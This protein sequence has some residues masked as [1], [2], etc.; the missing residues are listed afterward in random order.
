MSAWS[1]PVT[2]S[3]HLK[4]Q[5][6]KRTRAVVLWRQHCQGTAIHQLR[7]A[8]GNW[9]LSAGRFLLTA[10]EHLLKITITDCPL[11]SYVDS[12]RDDE[13]T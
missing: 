12:S 1:K 5:K 3:R 10:R 7:G 4:K 6:T 8:A 13:G 9:K 11:I 2:V